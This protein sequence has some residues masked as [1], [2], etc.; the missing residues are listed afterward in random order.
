MRLFEEPGRHHPTERA[1]C[2]E[3]RGRRLVAA[4]ARH[5]HAQVGAGNFF[6]EI[7]RPAGDVAEPR[8]HRPGAARRL[9]MVSEV[10]NVARRHGPLAMRLTTRSA[11]ASRAITLTVRGCELGA[12]MR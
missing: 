2:P 8:L 9:L 3:H 12:V 7:H 6:N 4:R 1:R 5:T 10:K 11:A